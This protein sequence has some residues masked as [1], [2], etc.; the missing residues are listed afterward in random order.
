M[1]VFPLL[2]V[3]DEWATGSE[4]L[5]RAPR[6]RSGN[7]D[8]GACVWS[9]SQ[10]HRS[11]IM[12]ACRASWCCGT[13]GAQQG[14]D[15]GPAQMTF[16]SDILGLRRYMASSHDVRLDRLHLAYFFCV[17]R[18]RTVRFARELLLLCAR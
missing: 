5:D 15:A 17:A 7:L 9:R 8:N 6:A 11:E 1:S 3:K 2:L 16:A 4:P 13:A 12:V 14:G 18:K 10:E